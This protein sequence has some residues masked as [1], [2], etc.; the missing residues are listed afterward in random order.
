MGEKIAWHIIEKYA[1]RMN[2]GTC[3]LCKGP[4]MTRKCPDLHDPLKGGFHSGGNGGQ[5]HSHDEEDSAHPLE[6]C[7]I[8]KPV[9]RIACVVALRKGACGLSVHPLQY[10]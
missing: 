4:H 7:A 5:G 9:E 8:V 2:S 6:G 3:T 1:I 10:V